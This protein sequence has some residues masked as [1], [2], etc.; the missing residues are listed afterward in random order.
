MCLIK[1]S[2]STDQLSM[3]DDRLLKGNHLL[4]HNYNN[5]K[6]DAIIRLERRKNCYKTQAES[7]SLM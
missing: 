1:L 3:V 5:N 4:L 6:G 2:N 7:I